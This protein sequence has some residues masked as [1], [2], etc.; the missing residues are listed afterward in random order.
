MGIH[1]EL[2]HFWE[3]S[4]LVPFILLQ[5]TLC[6]LRSHSI[7]IKIQIHL[8]R[9]SGGLNGGLISKSSKSQKRRKRKTKKRKSSWLEFI[10]P[11][12]IVK[13]KQTKECSCQGKKVFISK[14]RLLYRSNFVGREVKFCFVLFYFIEL[15]CY[16]MLLPSL[17]L[18]MGSSFYYVYLNSE[19]TFFLFI[20]PWSLLGTKITRFYTTV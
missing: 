18:F 4:T 20:K 14:E 9:S 3:L 1:R 6:L 16:Y 5:L 2:C 10:V 11:F 17:F 15:V 19:S 13:N 12:C 7:H 8:V